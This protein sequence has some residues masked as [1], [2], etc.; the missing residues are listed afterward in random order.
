MFPQGWHPQDPFALPNGTGMSLA[1]ITPFSRT[2]VG[3]VRYYYI[4]F[5][6]A[7]KD[8]DM[9]VG[10]SATE[11]APELS[12]TTPYDPFKTDIWILGRLFET[13]AIEVMHVV[14]V[15]TSGGIIMRRPASSRIG[16]PPSLGQQNDIEESC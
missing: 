5:D 9:I 4:D 2:A 7:S 11:A 14:A 16:V 12:D 15:V 10:L 8:R 13:F 3:G 6:I 1:G